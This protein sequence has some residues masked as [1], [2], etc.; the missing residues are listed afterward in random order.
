MA[1]RRPYDEHSA[2]DVMIKFSDMAYALHMKDMFQVA[3]NILYG[4]EFVI[5]IDFSKRMV[6]F[7]QVCQKEMTSEK[8]MME[9]HN[10]GT[11]QKNLSREPVVKHGRHS[12]NRLDKYCS[13]MLQ[14]QLLQHSVPT[15]GL[16]MVEEYRKHS[17][18][19]EPYY[20]CNLCAV[21]GRRD[22]MLNHLV[23][24]EHTDKYIK[25]RCI[26]STSTL[27]SRERKTFRRQLLD[28][29]G[30]N[31]DL[32]KRIIG[33][34]YFPEKWIAKDEIMPGGRNCKMLTEGVRCRSPSPVPGTSTRR[35]RSSSGSS[36]RSLSPV[37]HQDKLNTTI[38]LDSRSPS[39]KRKATRRTS[40]SP[41]LAKYRNRS[42]PPITIASSFWA[43]DKSAQVHDVEDIAVRLNFV[44]KTMHMPDSTLVTKNDVEACVNQ[45]FAISHI[46]HKW[47]LAQQPGPTRDRRIS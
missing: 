40:R 2:K 45:M 27:T 6:F 1:L 35:S 25:T 3:V 39:P 10:S 46:L 33:Y 11:H 42:P 37:Q 18:H 4:R 21:H 24:D 31:C 30:L 36:I 22:V 7:C 9:H 26:L 44:V 38:E 15:L 17:K 41:E 14:Y 20:K 8:A 29:E 5:R 34:E 12:S 13:C 43:N 23:G 28:F 32:I 47:E 19:R 16:M